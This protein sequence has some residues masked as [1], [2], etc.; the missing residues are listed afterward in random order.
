VVRATGVC[1]GDGALGGVAGGL[2]DQH[3][4]EVAQGGPERGV[5]GAGVAHGRQARAGEGVIDDQ[6]VH[7]PA[8]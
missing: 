1:S 7:D 3:E 6:D 4:G 5:V 2:V 8:G